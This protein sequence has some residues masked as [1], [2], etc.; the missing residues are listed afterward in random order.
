MPGRFASSWMIR[1]RFCHC[2]H[3]A[4]RSFWVLLKQRSESNDFDSASLPNLLL[5]LQ[6]DRFTAID[7]SDVLTALLL[8]STMKGLSC[9]AV[10]QFVKEILLAASYH[11]SPEPD[12]QNDAEFDKSQS[13]AVLRHGHATH[14]SPDV[15]RTLDLLEGLQRSRMMGQPT[16]PTIQVDVE[17]K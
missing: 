1:K 11:A 17:M 15:K 6:R 7:R 16:A 4:R 3:L 12:P 10:G 2:L 13:W 9:E 5:Q 14:L 8:S